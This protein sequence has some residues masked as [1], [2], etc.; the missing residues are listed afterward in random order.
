MLATAR[1]RPSGS[2]ELETRLGLHTVEPSRAASQVACWQK[3]G[4]GSGVA[5]ELRLRILNEE[6]F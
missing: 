2:Q 4:P 3:A 1:A 5:I 6:N